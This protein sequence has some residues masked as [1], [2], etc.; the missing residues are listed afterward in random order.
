[1]I[2]EDSCSILRSTTPSSVSTLVV[3][4]KELTSVND[5]TRKI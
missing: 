2:W 4:E 3:L 5:S 1:M